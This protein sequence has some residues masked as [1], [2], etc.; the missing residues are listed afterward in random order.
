MTNEV[1]TNE[2]AIKILSKIN[3]DCNCDDCVVGLECHKLDDALV[4]AIEALELMDKLSKRD[5]ERFNEM[6]Y[7]NGYNKGWED[8][9]KA[10]EQQPKT[11]HWIRQT[12]DYHD[13]YE[14]EHCGI[15]VGLD[16]IRNYCPNC[17][18]KM[19]ESEKWINFADD[20][21]PIIDVAE[22]EVEKC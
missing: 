16:D 15:A 2:E 10:L 3:C 20:L 21:I 8:G 1:M 19:A 18:A 12:D 13:Y 22:G 9:R 14:C 7:T 5:I 4:M 6:E 17:G 11:G